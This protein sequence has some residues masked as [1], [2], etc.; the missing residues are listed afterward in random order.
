MTV[1][2]TSSCL[3]LLQLIAIAGAAS[4]DNNELE[5]TELPEPLGESDIYY[6]SAFVDQEGRTNRKN[7][8]A[9]DASR[10]RLKN[11]TRKN[12]TLSAAIEAASLQGLHAMIDL[13]E[14]KEPEILRKGQ[15]THPKHCNLQILTVKHSRRI[16]RRQ[17]SGHKAEPV[18]RTNDKR[19]GCRG[20]RSFCQLVCRKETAREVRLSI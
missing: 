18:Q 9:I 13:Y 12:S 14:R 20:Q 17:P 16:S 3:L 7:I 19:L 15:K 8:S 10:Q 4:R 11:K 2:C 1:T 6:I 5:T